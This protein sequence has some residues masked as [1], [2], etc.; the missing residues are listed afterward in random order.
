M[1]VRV[2]GGAAGAGKKL[3]RG[4]RLD[5]L[6]ERLKGTVE[7]AEISLP[8]TWLVASLVP[9]RMPITDYQA[10]Y[11]AYELTKR[12][13]SDSVEKFVIVKNGSPSSPLTQ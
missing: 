7:C 8:V 2:L 11:L 12:C 13:A 3:E 4:I 9:A 5:A 1:R 10:K 6:M